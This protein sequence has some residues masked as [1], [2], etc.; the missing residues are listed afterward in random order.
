MSFFTFSGKSSADVHRIN[1]EMLS[2]FKE[3]TIRCLI[4]VV[5]KMRTFQHRR[6]LIKVFSLFRYSERM[7][8][9][10]CFVLVSCIYPAGNNRARKLLNIT[11]QKSLMVGEKKLN[12][13]SIMI[14]C[15]CN[16]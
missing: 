8:C 9:V 14:L 10:V 16:T 3:Q 12:N 15:F 4:I 7:C 2:L 11:E 13:A 6:L 1:E 5:L